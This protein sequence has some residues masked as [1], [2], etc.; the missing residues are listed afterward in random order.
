MPVAISGGSRIRTNIPAENAYNAL[1]ASNNNIALRQLRLSTNKRINAASDDV[2]GY[3]T[4]RALAA[5][6]S[7][8][9]SAFKSVGQAKNVTAIAQD[10]LDEIQ[11]LINDIKT[12]AASASS[13]AT[14]TDE[15]VA[16]ARAAYR[17]AQQIQTITDS[18]VFG[19][20]Q[21][22]QGQFTGDW[23]I[24]FYADNTLLELEIDLSR[25]NTDYNLTGGASDDFN[26]NATSEAL[27]SVG[28]VTS[29]FAGVEGL[30]LEDLNEI[31]TDDLGIFS[32]DNINAT[33]T[34]LSQAIDNV[35]K[36]ASYIGGIEVRL[37]SQERLL[38]SQIINYKAAISLIE[39][40]DVAVEQLELIKAQF[41]QQTS[42]ISLAQANQN[43]QSFLLLFR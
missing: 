34:S 40:A 27:A 42:L 33:L 15:K 25:N 23:T 32:E 10:A 18:T 5:R 29:N 9:E 12:S 28:G 31:T 41:A 19:G 14:G 24:G 21:L 8:L 6:N 35:N 16:L 37:S 20:R 4:S 26:L 11:G 17:L 2:A 7:A 43:P 30:R 3:I 1:L 22:L 38:S 39:D 36:V 13:G